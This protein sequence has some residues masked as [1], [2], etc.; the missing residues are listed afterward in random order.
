MSK[1]TV[2]RAAI[3]VL[4]ALNVAFIWS[5]SIFSREASTEQS[6]GVIGLLGT[7]FPFLERLPAKLIEIIVRKLAHFAEF[8]SLGVLSAL[9]LW[10]HTSARG[11]SADF[12]PASPVALMLCLLVASTDETIQLFAD[13]GSMVSDIFLD[14][15]GAV[16]GFFVLS[17][18][19]LII[20][21]KKGSAK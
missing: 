11:R 3:Y 8:A 2:F 9:A 4:I 19:R 1:R 14:F 7:L 6:D 13:R 21:F 20:L 5:M 18:L 12:F 15:S 17:V 10:D 16:F